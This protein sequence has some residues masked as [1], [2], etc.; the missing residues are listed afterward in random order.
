MK[1]KYKYIHFENQTP[2]VIRKTNGTWIL[3][4]N[5][6]DNPIGMIR[7]NRHWKKYYLCLYSS[8]DILSFEDLSDIIDFLKQLKGDERAEPWIALESL[9]KDSIKKFWRYPSLL[10]ILTK[11]EEAVVIQSRYIVY[12]FPDNIFKMNKKNQKYL[13]DRLV[14]RMIIDWKKD[15]EEK[16]E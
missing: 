6:L 11:T 4:Y 9:I 2:N 3:K 12:R 15:I 1:T 14:Q 10:W 5:F 8:D 7:W 16:N 13:A